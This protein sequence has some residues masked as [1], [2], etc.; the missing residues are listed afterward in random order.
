MATNHNCQ[1]GETIDDWAARVR[2]QPHPVE[3]DAPDSGF[4]DRRKAALEEIERQI[5]AEAE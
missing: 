2:A 1:E 4:Y 3:G 5:K